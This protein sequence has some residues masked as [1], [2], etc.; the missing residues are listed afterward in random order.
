T[1][2]FLS[3]FFSS[4]YCSILIMFSFPFTFTQQ[5]IFVLYHEYLFCFVFFSQNSVIKSH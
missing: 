1:V 2:V 3:L 4:M 5:N